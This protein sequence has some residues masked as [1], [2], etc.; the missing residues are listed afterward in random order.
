M[1]KKEIVIILFVMVALISS[2]AVYTKNKNVIDLKSYNF[3][4]KVP[5]INP[6]AEVFLQKAYPQVVREFPKHYSYYIDNVRLIKEGFRVRLNKLELLQSG[7]DK[8]GNGYVKIDGSVIAVFDNDT[9]LVGID[10][11]N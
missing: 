3:K 9:V 1:K 10:K 7:S 6:E 4:F 2:L 11:E 5:K 8:N